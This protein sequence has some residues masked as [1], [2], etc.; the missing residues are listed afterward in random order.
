M[1]MSVTSVKKQKNCQ[2]R[3]DILRERPHCTILTLTFNVTFDNNQHI[4]HFCFWER[5]QKLF[6]V[7]FCFRTDRRTDSTRHGIWWW[8]IIIIIT[9]L[10]SNC[11]VCVLRTHRWLDT[12]EDD[13][14]I[15]R[16]LDVIAQG[17]RLL[18][19]FSSTSVAMWGYR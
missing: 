9:D 10:K 11:S 17:Y 14:L 16:Q 1:V 3:V 19:Y 15:E 5:S 2:P 18:L 4:G 12:S 7:L 6:Y 8:W 13:G